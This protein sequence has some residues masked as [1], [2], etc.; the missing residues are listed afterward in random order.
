MPILIERLL[1]LIRTNCAG[2]ISLR[3]TLE[4]ATQ[5]EINECYTTEIPAEYT[6]DAQ[7]VRDTIANAGLT[8]PP[9]VEIVVIQDATAGNDIVS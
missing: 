7:L 4:S 5:V 8:F 6:E 1:E 3:T 9:Y 2:T